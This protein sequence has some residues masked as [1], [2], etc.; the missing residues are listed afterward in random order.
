MKTLFAVLLI[1]FVFLPLDSAAVQ[2]QKREPQTISTEPKEVVAELRIGDQKLANVQ[3]E[4]IF[5]PSAGNA[6]DTLTGTL[7]FNVSE[8]ERK[9]I[10]TM[11][12]KPLDDV[13][14]FVKKGDVMTVFVK[15]AE[16]PDLRFEF[17]V[18]HQNF[19]PADAEIEFAGTTLRFQPFVLSFKES[20]QELSQL[21]CVWAKRIYSGRGTR[22]AAQRFSK[23]IKG[24]DPDK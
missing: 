9:R 15:H 6:D 16:C 11:M 1:G 13:P 12:K 23:V 21:L 14:S 7:A 19:N 8:A 22:G 24:E 20:Q 3:G 18:R 2:A 17:F 4:A 10:A 5:T